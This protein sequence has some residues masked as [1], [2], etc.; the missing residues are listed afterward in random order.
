MEWVWRFEDARGEPVGDPPTSEEF[1][2]QADAESWLGE[3]WRS[4][5]AAG[6]ARVTLLHDGRAVYGPM[7]LDAP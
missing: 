6:V 2:S 5:L 1:P 7:S 4:L 3:Q